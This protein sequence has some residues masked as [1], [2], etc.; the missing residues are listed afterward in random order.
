MKIKLLKD[1][2]FMLGNGAGWTRYYV[3]DILNA[4]HETLW[5]YNTGFG[6]VFKDEAMEVTE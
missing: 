1:V 4:T 6:K 2:T 3:G 5:Y